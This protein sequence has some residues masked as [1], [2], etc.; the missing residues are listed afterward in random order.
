MQRIWCYSILLI[1]NLGFAWG[2]T[3]PEHFEVH[4]HRGARAR[5][6]EETLYGFQYALA[7]GADVLE[8]DMNVTSD[9]HLV[10]HHDMQL[11]TDLCQSQSAELRNLVRPLISELTL[12]QLKTYECGSRKDSHFPN[13]ELHK[14]AMLISLSDFLDWLQNSP[15]PAAK[16]VRLNFETKIDPARPNW[17]VRPSVFVELF[18]AELKAHRFPLERVILESFDFRTIIYAKQKY[19]QMMT[20][21]LVDKINAP[22]GTTVGA[23]WTATHADYLS[24]SGKWLSSSKVK[25]AH[26]LGMKVVPWTLNW[27]IMWWYFRRMGVDGIITDDPARLVQ[28]LK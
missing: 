1:S 18:I 17:T 24:P 16:N 5:Q 12:A 23:I 14:D 3:R 22:S 28:Y 4:G 20:S 11:N 25:E 2:S 15:L 19:P 8:A 27:R 10:L 7:A 6:P 9:G 26:R 13:R 21:A